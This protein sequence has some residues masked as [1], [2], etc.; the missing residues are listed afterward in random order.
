MII[1]IDVDC[2]LRDIIPPTLVWWEQMTGIKKCRKDIDKWEVPECLDIDLA[3][4]SLSEFYRKWFM[5]RRIWRRAAPILGAIGA[6][7]RLH[8]LNEIAIITYQPTYLQKLWTLEWLDEHL[9]DDMHYSLMYDP[10][11]F[12]KRK[13]LIQ[14]DVLIDDGP[15]NFEGFA[16]K[17]ILFSQPWNQNDNVHTRIY[18]WDD[19]V[20]FDTLSDIGEG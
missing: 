7:A 10:L 20:L 14:A 18:G 8:E 5:E 17:A 2:V 15:H 4:I 19:P 16:G 1:G 3:G 6:I 13:S 9:R 11:V 12:T